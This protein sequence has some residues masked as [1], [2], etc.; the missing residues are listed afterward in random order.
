MMQLDETMAPMMR[1]ANREYWSSVYACDFREVIPHISAP[2]LLIFPDPGSIYSVKVGQ[3]LHSQIRDSKLVIP[4]G[5]GIGTHLAILDP[6]VD[7]AFISDY[8]YV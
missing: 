2:T 8:F 1:Y 5:T 3:W 4:K 7:E 6:V